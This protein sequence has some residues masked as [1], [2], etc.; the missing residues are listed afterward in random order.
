MMGQGK[1]IPPPSIG[2][3]ITVTRQKNRHLPATG[4]L[5]S[6]MFPAMIEVIEV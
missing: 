4:G 3:H 5:K 2:K 6:E 1:D